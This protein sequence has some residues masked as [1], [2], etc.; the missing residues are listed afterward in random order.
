MRSSDVVSTDDSAAA[1]ANRS[2]RLPCC[3]AVHQSTSLK[4]NPDTRPPDPHPSLIVGVRA[5]AIALDAPLYE[6][7]QPEVWSSRGDVQRSLYLIRSL[8]ASKRFKLVD[9]EQQLPCSPDLVIM[10]VENPEP[11]HPDGDAAWLFLY[12]GIIPI[13]GSSDFGHYFVNVERS[14]DLF[15][16]PWKRTEVI[17][18][19]NPLLWVFSGWERKVDPDAGLEEFSLFIGEN[20]ERLTSDH[21]RRGEECAI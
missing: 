14:E 12:L 4:L 15:A 19:F 18:W 6:D 2:A 13:W 20:W 17:W 1:A 21:Q 9:F 11:F 5:P 8:R 7:A 10:A 3:L 16:F